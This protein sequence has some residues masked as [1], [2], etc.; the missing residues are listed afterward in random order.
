MRPCLT[1]EAATLTCIAFS[2]L[3][4]G[5]LQKACLTWSFA[6]TAEQ[7]S[8]HIGSGPVDAMAGWWLALW[9]VLAL[10]TLFY[11]VR[12]RLP[13]IK[14]PWAPTYEVPGERKNFPGS[15][16]SDG[17]RIGRGSWQCAKAE[18]YSARARQL[19]RLCSTL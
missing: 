11:F 9:V 16:E 8:S 14:S 4:Y 7:T 13:V 3:S 18:L 1:P 15:L 12:S 5:T 17:R 2:S 19:Q 6:Q 10:A